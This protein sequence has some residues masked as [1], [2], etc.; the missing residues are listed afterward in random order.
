MGNCKLEHSLK[1]D[2]GPEIRKALLVLQAILAG[3]RD[4]TLADDPGLKY[5]DAVELQ[6]L[7]EDLK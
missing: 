1:S 4:P 3:A 2:P 6:F 7:L 5:N